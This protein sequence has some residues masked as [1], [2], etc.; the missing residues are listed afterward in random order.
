MS[1]AKSTAVDEGRMV[2]RS[3]ATVIMEHRQLRRRCRQIGVTVGAESTAFKEGAATAT[4]I[5]EQHL[6]FCRLRYGLPVSDLS[7]QRAQTIQ[8]PLAV[9]R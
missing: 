3:A 5:E 6:H 7:C 1:G 4:I 2:S 9:R 8:S